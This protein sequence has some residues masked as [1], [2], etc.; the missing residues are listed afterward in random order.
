MQILFQNDE[1]LVRFDGNVLEMQNSRLLRSVDFSA[2]FPATRSLRRLDTGVEYADSEGAECMADFAGI[3]R[4]GQYGLSYRRE[5]EI[6]AEL[7]EGGCFDGAHLRVEA[8]FGEPLQGVRFDVVWRLYPGLPVFSAECAVAS[9]V[10]PRCYWSGRSEFR[11]GWY[12]RLAPEEYSGAVD[13]FRLA[14]GLVPRYSTEL[15]ARTDIHDDLVHTHPV[16]EGQETF[17]GSLFWC[18]GEEAGVLILQEAPPSGERRDLAEFD[19]TCRSRMVRSLAWNQ[20][21]W[22]LRPGRTIRSERSVLLAVSGAAERDLLLKQYLRVRFPMDPGKYSAMVNPW[23]CGNFRHRVSEAFLQDEICAAGELG[24]DCYQID[25]EWQEGKG[26][27]RLID[28]NEKITPA[29]WEISEARLNGTFA[30]LLPVAEAAGVELA[31]WCAPS[32]NVEYRDWESFRDFLLDFHHRW[33]FRFFK[34]DG[35]RI[36]SAEAEENL[37]KLLRSVREATGGKIYFNLDTTNG[38]RPGYYRMLEYGNIFLENR[39]V[40]HTWGLGYHP[41]KTLRSVWKLAGVTRLQTL[42]VE[43]PNPG[44]INRDFYRDKGM[45]Q[46]DIYPVEYWA[47]IALFANPLLWMTPST[48]AP[49]TRDRIRPLLDLWHKHYPAIAEGEIFPVGGEPDGSALTGLYSTAGYL[50]LYR[51]ANAPETAKIELPHPASEWKLLAGK[52]KLT[53]GRATLPDHPRFA[54]FCR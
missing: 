37:E 24:A 43:V 54:L 6:R 46:P 20:A 45:T 29:F 25:D 12:P 27:G 39:Y 2:G 41:E 21:P 53:G 1:F 9:E 34:I 33:G 42:Q 15:I 23:G 36:R 7:V 50:I 8:A 35:V 44:D 18:A 40:C 28:V 3:N 47:A 32:M 22:E 19:Y 4:P 14:G 11:D 13:G 17:T 26:L 38:Q 31:L 5:G 52:G 16:G 51:E 48:L 49:E 30:T 10:T